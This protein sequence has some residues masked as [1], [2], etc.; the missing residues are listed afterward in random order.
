MKKLTSVILLFCL[1]FSLISCT[2]KSTVSPDFSVYCFAAGEADAFLLTT[3]GGTVL[4]DTG[5]S[6]CGGKIC[7]RLAEYGTDS[8][9]YMIITHF[10]GDHVGGA[11]K[12]LKK[13]PVTHVYTSCYTSDADK[14]DNFVSALSYARTDSVTVREELSFELDGVSYTVYPP[15]EE[16]YEK[17]SSNNS[18]L[19][20]SAVFGEK[21]FLF[22]GDAEKERLSE[23]VRIN[24]TDYD[25]I[26]MP[27]HGR[28]NSSI[29]QLISSVTPEYAVI[30]C[31]ALSADRKTTGVLD[32]NGVETYYCAENSVTFVSDGINIG[33]LKD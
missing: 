18:S 31:P 33:V 8:I 15:E 16:E 21:K 27:H 23:F 30:T 7:D 12:V 6:D 5:E 11:S 28:W 13:Y 19:I 1:I 25:F 17:D 20:V 22:C 4:I 32:E 29:S 24:E 14:Y 3:A 10:D 9:D 2:E 26:K